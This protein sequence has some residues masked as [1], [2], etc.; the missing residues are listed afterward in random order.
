MVSPL[1]RHK[2]HNGIPRQGCMSTPYVQSH[3][4]GTLWISVEPDVPV[5]EG[6]ETV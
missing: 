4:Q 3:R 6:K 5:P 1:V 2:V